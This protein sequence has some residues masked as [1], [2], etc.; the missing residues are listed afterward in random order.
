MLNKV[1]MHSNGAL[2]VLKPVFGSFGADAW[3]LACIIHFSRL[4]PIC[5]Y[6]STHKQQRRTVQRI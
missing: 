5:F 1:V 3:S 6:I 4:T 2:S